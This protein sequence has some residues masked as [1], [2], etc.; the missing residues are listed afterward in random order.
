MN[1]I[2]LSLLALLFGGSYCAPLNGYSSLSIADNIDNT[3]GYEIA[4]ETSN[5]KS[6]Q[7]SDT[8][9]KK[10]RM[11]SKQENENVVSEDC[12]EINELHYG[13]VTEECVE[14]EEE[15]ETLVEECVE[16]EE[17]CETVDNNEGSERVPSIHFQDTEEDCEEEGALSN[18]SN[19]TIE[20]SSC[21]EEGGAEAMVDN[22]EELEECEEEI[23]QDCNETKL[24]DCDEDYDE[25][26]EISEECENVE[27]NGEDEENSAENVR[28]FPLSSP[29]LDNSHH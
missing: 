21:E 20:E 25:C 1:Y 14:V 2:A 16:V 27:E 26:E 15:C 9:L 4:P 23:N 10:K 19:N 22:C 18:Y 3:K 8:L 5:S 12:D 7:V 11:S 29:L 28:P 24:E 6:I 17:E 13:T